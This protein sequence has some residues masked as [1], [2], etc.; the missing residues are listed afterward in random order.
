VLNSFL[1]DAI[2]NKQPEKE[3]LY[4]VVFVSAKS[5]PGMNF[6]IYGEAINRL[7]HSGVNL[8]RIINIDEYGCVEYKLLDN[9]KT[10][11]G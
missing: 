11:N 4:G 9:S 6:A 8:V 7:G 1:I 2:I 5:T 10:E 3:D